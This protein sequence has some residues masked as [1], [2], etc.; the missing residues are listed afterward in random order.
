MGTNENNKVTVEPKP[1]VCSIEETPAAEGLAPSMRPDKG[2]INLMLVLLCLA[3]AQGWGYMRSWVVG[4][5]N[6]R[7]INQIKAPSPYTSANLGMK[8]DNIYTL[9]LLGD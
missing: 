8:R 9:Q 2:A 5:C 6:S 7:C 4:W 3:F 1:E